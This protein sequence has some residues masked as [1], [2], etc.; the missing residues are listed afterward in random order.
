MSMRRCC[1]VTLLELSHMY[2]WVASL[3]LK[4]VVVFELIGI[5]LES[6]VRSFFERNMWFICHST[7]LY[8]QINRFQSKGQA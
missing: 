7:A 1:D 2:P 8:I 4:L 3:W 6:N 5:L